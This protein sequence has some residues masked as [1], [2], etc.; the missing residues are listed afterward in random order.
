GYEPAAVARLV[1]DLLAPQ[2]AT[3]YPGADERVELCGVG[4]PVLRLRKDAAA[5]DSALVVLARL[6]Q[7][8]TI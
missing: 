5:Y 7:T 8:E 3:R 4:L 2:D 6:Q 1:V